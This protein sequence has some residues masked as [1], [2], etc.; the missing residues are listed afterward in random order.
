VL[1]TGD[2]PSGLRVSAHAFSASARDKIT[3]AGG[4]ATQL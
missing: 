2:A 4:T 1:G 3:A